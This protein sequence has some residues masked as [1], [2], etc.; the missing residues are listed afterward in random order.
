MD[1]WTLTATAFMVLLLS[2]FPT[3]TASASPSQLSPKGPESYGLLLAVLIDA[4]DNGTLSDATSELLSNIF[5]G[6]LISPVTGE[7]LG[8]IRERLVSGGQ[9]PF[10][11]L[12]AVLDDANEK[13]SLSNSVSDVLS[14]LLIENLIAP[15]TGE[16][17]GQVRERLNAN[18]F[19]SKGYRYF[20]A[21]EWKLAIESFTVAIYLHPNDAEYYQRRGLVYRH[22]GENVNAIEDFTEAIRLDPGTAD[23]Y[24]DR[25]T[26]FHRMGNYHKALEDNNKAIELKPDYAPFYRERGVS[27]LP[28]R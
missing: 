5:I 25:A 21:G 20:D 15:A 28:P 14:N 27:A 18:F 7:T 16:E 12:V 9:I 24:N 8:Q 19:V 17:L 23:F 4:R 10:D 1:K 11:F 22:I 6:Y 3:H 2:T 26:A 13:G